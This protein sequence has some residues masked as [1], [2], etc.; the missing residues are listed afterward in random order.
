[1]H[2]AK[3]IKVDA[4][5]CY[6]ESAILNGN[7]V[8]GDIQFYEGD[9]CPIINLENGHVLNWIVGNTA[10]IHYKIGDYERYWLLDNSM[11]IIS[12]W[13]DYCIPNSFL[14]VNREGYGDYIIFTINEN[15]YIKD[16][17]QPTIDTEQC[18]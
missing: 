10:Q 8:N 11:N 3:Y 14:C 2:A 16:W 18:L 1:M 13:K 5:I 12:R 6:S 9:W 7:V 17:K 15:G 4:G